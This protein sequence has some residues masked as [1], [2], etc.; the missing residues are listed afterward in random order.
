M[1]TRITTTDATQVSDARTSLVATHHCPAARQEDDS[2][3]YFW[4][5][6]HIL[7]QRGENAQH[8]CAS[9]HCI[10]MMHHFKHWYIIGGTHWE[11]RKLEASEII[12]FGTVLIEFHLKC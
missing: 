6:T 10:A 1:A 9:M 11:E 3:L 2:C 12:Q 7:G 4:D 5:S 8:V